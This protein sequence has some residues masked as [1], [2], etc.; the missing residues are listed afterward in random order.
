MTKQEIYEQIVQLTSE[1]HATNVTEKIFSAAKEGDSKKVEK[2]FDTFKEENLDLYLRIL[3]LGVTIRTISY[4]GPID[5]FSS[6]EDE[7]NG[8]YVFDSSI[9]NAETLYIL[10]LL[11]G[12]DEF[13]LFNWGTESSINFVNAIKDSGYMELAHFVD[14]WSIFDLGCEGKKYQD[15]YECLVGIF[16]GDFE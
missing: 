15:I 5:V 9:I 14:D 1:L 7:E 6:E 8:S 16:K 12:I 13:Y 3:N 2:V 11:G 10:I 4:G